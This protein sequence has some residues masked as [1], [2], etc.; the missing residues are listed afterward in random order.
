MSKRRMANRPKSDSQHYNYP[1]T[2][3]ETRLSVYVGD[4][5][6]TQSI[7]L[8]TAVYETRLACPERC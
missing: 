1:A 5:H 7:T 8:R 3:Q 2:A 6:G 4:L